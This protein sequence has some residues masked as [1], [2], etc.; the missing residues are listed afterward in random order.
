M[1]EERLTDIEIRI[2]YQE[3]TIQALN[4]V[5]LAQGLEITQLHKHLEAIQN[6]LEESS[7]S[8][9]PANERPP[10]Y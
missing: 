6:K 5:I 8:I 1:S 3:R 9:G 7:H 4:D 10:H 2:E